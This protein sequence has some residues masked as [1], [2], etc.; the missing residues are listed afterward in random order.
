MF[1]KRK[2]KIREQQHRLLLSQL[3][4]LKGKLDEQ[5]QL[6]NRSIDPSDEVL[7]RAKITEG[8]YSLL[9][10]EARANHA[11]KSKQ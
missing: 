2:G 4:M 10:R 1:F 8:L 3:E 6:I 9:L 11:S 7:N 5:K